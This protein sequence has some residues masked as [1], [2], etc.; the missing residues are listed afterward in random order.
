MF[1]SHVNTSHF[2]T[3]CGAYATI[4]HRIQTN[5]FTFILHKNVVCRHNEITVSSVSHRHTCLGYICT[6][7]SPFLYVFP[8][9]KLPLDLHRFYVI[10]KREASEQGDD[11]STDYYRITSHKLLLNSK[12]C[13]RE[14]KH[15][16]VTVFIGDF[17]DT[18]Q[19]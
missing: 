13:F 18:F 12:K 7:F 14:S 10:A 17:D 9:I 8:W 1:P 11:S 4:S 5:A 3:Q 16:S 6:L 2:Y 19:I 15:G